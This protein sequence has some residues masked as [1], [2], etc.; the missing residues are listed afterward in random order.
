MSSCL[1]KGL[2][3]AILLPACVGVYGWSGSSEKAWNLDKVSAW[4]LANIRFP[5]EAY[6]YG[7]AGV[8]Q[9]CLSVS[10]DGKVFLPGRLNTLHPAYAEEIERVVANA[11]RCADVPDVV[12]EAYRCV[13]VDF[14]QYI[15]EERCGN[16]MQVSVHTPPVFRPKGVKSSYFEGREAYMEWLCDE[17]RASESLSA[18]ATDT[19]AV[20]YTV[21]SKG[22]VKDFS[23]LRCKEDWLKDG[24]KRAARRSP[25]WIPATADGYRDIDVVIRDRIVFRSDA[26]GELSCLA[27]VDDVYKRDAAMPGDYEGIVY[28]PDKKPVYQNGGSFRKDALRPLGEMLRQR[29]IN[30][31]YS[32]S[33]SFVVEKDGTVSGIEF[34]RLPDFG[35]A[36]IQADSIVAD[37]IGKMRWTPAKVGDTPVRYLYPFTCKYRDSSKWIQR[38]Q[39]SRRKRLYRVTSP[40]DAFGKHFIDLQANPS[41]KGYLYIQNDGSFHSYPFNSSGMFNYNKFYKGMFYYRRN[42]VRGNLA[43]KYLNDVYDVYAR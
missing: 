12:E 9:I 32:I 4:V 7:M 27:C 43:K 36:G 14:Y 17:V 19:V 6:G 28:N 3:F 23:V 13:E 5:E 15:P 37:A 35:A 1:F 38:S 25:R 26:K 34:V 18:G 39:E 33:G 29:G 2:L 30:T 24:L 21:T 8:E 41:E 20:Q 40:V 10:W 22:K 16:M 42:G 11:P 31:E